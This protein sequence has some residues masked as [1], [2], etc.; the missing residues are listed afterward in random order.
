MTALQRRVPSSAFCDAYGLVAG[1]REWSG[2]SL[3][4]TECSHRID[5]DFKVSHKSGACYFAR[6]ARF[7]GVTAHVF[8]STSQPQVDQTECPKLAIWRATLS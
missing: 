8:I 5:R 4:A 6:R 2:I 3:N 1:G 7:A